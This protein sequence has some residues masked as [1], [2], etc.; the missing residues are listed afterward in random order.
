MSSV[1]GQRQTSAEAA[2]TQSIKDQRILLMRNVRKH[3]RLYKNEFLRT[4]FLH[5]H[6]KQQIWDKI[7]QDSGF[8][9]TEDAKCKW[10]SLINYLRQHLDSVA[11]KKLRR[12]IPNSNNPDDKYVQLNDWVYYSELEFVVPYVK[13]AASKQSNLG[14]HLE[15]SPSEIDMIIDGIEEEIN[16]ENQ[17]NKQKQKSQEVKRQLEKERGK[18]VELKH[19]FEDGH[20]QEEMSEDD[21]ILKEYFDN[22]LKSTLKLPRFHQNRIRQKLLDC[23]NEQKE[24]NKIN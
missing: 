7:A 13:Y 23:V 11:Q 9:K 21:M 18:K 6:E 15:I 3:P 8:E 5:R 19:K 4:P 10:R 1:S 16:N 24:L 14:N 2:T 22:M 17:D 12:Y 20:D